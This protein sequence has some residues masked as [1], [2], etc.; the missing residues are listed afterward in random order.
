M[1]LPTLTTQEVARFQKIYLEQYGIEQSEIEART[2]LT[3]LVQFYYLTGG[4]DA[5][6]QRTASHYVQDIHATF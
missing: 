4:D 2:E 3:R 6:R 1:L 5:Y